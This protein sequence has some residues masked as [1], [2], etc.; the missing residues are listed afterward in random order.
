MWGGSISS[1]KGIDLVEPL[2]HALAVQMVSYFAALGKDDVD[3]P[4]MAKS[5]T[6]E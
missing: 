5:V 2:I 4:K 3:Q 1:A 6:V